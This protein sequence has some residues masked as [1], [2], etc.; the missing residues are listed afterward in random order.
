MAGASW[1]LAIV[2]AGAA[3][4]MTAIQAARHAPSG[5]RILLLDARPKIGAKILMS[6]GTRCNVTHQQVTE[7]DFETEEGRVLRDILKNFSSEKTV[8]FFH[9]LGVDLLLEPGGKYFPS[10]HSARTVLDA[11]LQECERAGVR[12]ETEKKVTQ[13]MRRHPE[14]FARHPERS[15]AQGRLREGS[16]IL[17]PFGPQDDNF[18]EITGKEFSFYAK[19]VVLCTGGLSYPA[20]GCDGLG[21]EIAKSFGHSLIFTTPAL[22]PLQTDDADWKSLSGVTLPVR[23]TLW[24]GSK[25]QAVFEDSF[26]FTHFGFSGPAALNISRHWIRREEKSSRKLTGNFLP[27]ETEED[28]RKALAAAAQKY[29]NRR[30]KSII[31]EKVPERFAEVFLRKLGIPDAV[32]LNQLKRGE[33]ELLV[34]SLFHF[35]LSVTG[36]VGYGK[37]EAT[38][39]GVDLSEVHPK[40]LESKLQPGL[41]FA[42]EILDVDGRIGGFNFQ[43]AW[44]SGFAAGRAAAQKSGGNHETK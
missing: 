15:S 38:A 21:Y 30:L 37:A 39:G 5:A 41:F 9:G 3:G 8:E 23:L 42:G 33:R 26:L 44:S 18:F 35:P 11:L 12:L 17:R 36:V 16:E 4:L 20:T 19:T 13:I 31:S 28:F 2:G 29:P 1:D 14:P 43:W 25:K 22:T 10:T 40:T 24:T 6:G 27:S 34:R 32:I 7:K